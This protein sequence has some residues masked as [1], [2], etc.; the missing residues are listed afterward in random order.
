MEVDDQTV[1]NMS[2][3]LVILLTLSDKINKVFK[4]MK[5][6]LKEVIKQWQLCY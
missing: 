4:T 1:Y 2:K 5:I 6:R 3:Y